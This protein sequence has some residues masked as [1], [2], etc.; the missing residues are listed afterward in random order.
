VKAADVKQ[1]IKKYLMQYE[2]MSVREWE[3][4]VRDTY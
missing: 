3:W 1:K 4:F 2:K